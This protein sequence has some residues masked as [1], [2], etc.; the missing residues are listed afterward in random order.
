MSEYATSGGWSGLSP[1]NG[2][3]PEGARSPEAMQRPVQEERL[4]GYFE[5]LLAWHPVEAHIVAAPTGVVGPGHY[6]FTPLV[7]QDT[8]ISLF[9]SEFTPPTDPSV[10]YAG[11]GPYLDTRQAI[12]LVYDDMLIGVGGAGVDMAGRLTIV[13]LQNVSGINRSD[14]R[15][16]YRAGFHSGLLWRETLVPAWE[17]IARDIGADAVVIQSH[18]NNRWVQARQ[19]GDYPLT[20]CKQRCSMKACRNTPYL[21]SSATIPPTMLA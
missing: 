20:Y 13:Q 14:G 11:F 21:I 17:A 8:K 6:R 9:V 4:V 12:G 3:L 7:N 5:D 10:A 2:P 1:Q 16:F 18:Q 19:N 15:R